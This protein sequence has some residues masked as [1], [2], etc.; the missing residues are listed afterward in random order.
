MGRFKSSKSLIKY[1]PEYIISS[2]R[3]LSHP[4]WVPEP[5]LVECVQFWK[6]P[7]FHVNRILKEGLKTQGE[8][9]FLS[10]RIRYHFPRVHLESNEVVNLVTAF[11]LLLNLNIANIN[12]LIRHLSTTFP[13][14]TQMK[15]PFRG[16]DEP[17]P[18]VCEMFLRDKIRIAY[19]YMN[20]N[21]TVYPMFTRE[22]A[23]CLLYLSGEGDFSIP[24]SVLTELTRLLRKWI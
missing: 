6:N 15:S 18:R 21:D 2:F 12:K 11:E 1:L 19:R 13:T 14:I 9:Y 24:V 16:G 10:E 7:E 5:H 22:V 3:L 8:L 20:E 23:N 4:T 17:P